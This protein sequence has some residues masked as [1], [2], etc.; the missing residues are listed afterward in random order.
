MDTFMDLVVISE[1]WNKTI[2]DINCVT[3]NEK[4]FEAMLLQLI[5]AEL[6]QATI[7]RGNSIWVVCREKETEEEMF[8]PHCY[9]V[10]KNWKG[11]NLVQQSKKQTYNLKNDTNN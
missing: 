9:K 6:I 11:L 1:Y 7:W 10:N 4:H 2:F 3:L 8:P 5:V